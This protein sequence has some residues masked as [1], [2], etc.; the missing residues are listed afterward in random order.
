MKG[1]PNMKQLRADVSD[2]IRWMREQL[3]HWGPEVSKAPLAD[4]EYMRVEFSTFYGHL[5]YSLDRACILGEH[6]ASERKAARKAGKR[7]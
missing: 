2:R 6:I 1:K 3:E 7:K 4:L 5:R